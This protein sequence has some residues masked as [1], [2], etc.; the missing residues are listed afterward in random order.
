MSSSPS[1]RRLFLHQ[2]GFASLGAPP[3]IQ[4]FGALG[5]TP[6]PA[7]SAA[8]VAA[9][10]QALNRF[11]RMMQEWLVAQVRQAEAEGA[12]LRSALKTK[13]DAE[14]YV[15]NVRKKI[16]A[17][18]GPEPEKTPLNAR[19]IRTVER[20]TYRIENVIFESRP[21]FP[22]TANLYVPKGPGGK[23]PGVVGVCGHSLNGKA[24]EAYQSF[25]QGLARMG[26][27][28]LIFDPAGQ[29]ER[30]EYLDGLK[31]RYKGGVGEHIQA[32]NQLSLIGE[33]LA[34]WFAWDGIRALDYLLTRPEVAPNHVGIT[35]NSGGGTQTTWLC[36]VEPRFTMA[37]PACFVTTFR[38]NAENELPA[39]TEQCPPGVL[40]QHLDHA[41]F[42]VAMAPKPVVILAQEK[43]FFDARG[44]EEAYGRLKGLYTLLGKPDNIQLHVGS[45]YHG[46]TQGN[47]EAMYR[48]FNSVT[49]VSNADK[50][51]ALVIEKDETLWCT[52][53]GQVSELHAR[54]IFSF[55]KERSQSL[56]K[57][58]G[59]LKEEALRTAVMDLLKMP[60]AQGVPDFRILR[61]IGGR[62]YPLKN[63]AAYAV[64][65]EPGIHALVTR[66]QEDPLISRPP[67]GPARAVLYVS[68]LSADAELREEPLVA[69]LLKEEPSA[70]FFGCDLRGIGDSRPDICGTDQFLKPYGSD[71]FLSA[72]GVMLDRPYLGQKVFDVLRVLEW[73]AA[74]GHEEVHLAGK[75]W[76][77]LAAAFAALFS[78][79]V[80]QVTLKGALRSFAEVAET[81]D[82]R[83]PYSALLPGVLKQF[84]LPDCYRALEAKK[85]RLLD[86]WGAEDGLKTV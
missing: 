83:W 24:A 14:A 74:Q 36:G 13:E 68:H 38:R 45:D 55:T 52:P 23:M 69:E 30:F 82:Y 46:Y 2:A 63:H 49:G 71:Y 26:Y 5:A 62:K 80:R 16:R 6:A 73:V 17:C 53:H 43:D 51:P 21:G 40:A 58:R 86:P 77:A 48:F 22:V 34:A 78:P 3:L 27:V 70:A 76:G 54:T 44:S 7:Q 56:S 42:L 59:A 8:K 32:G 84:D 1:S 29:G 41:D 79:R 61:T 37:A 85:L 10:I 25:A 15:R 57:Q 66:L 18:F 12:R 65:T 35:G 28:V 75:G 9:D 67:K 19:T 33:S 81:E 31:S 64:E 47:R 11:P 4:M 20:D 50:E 39:D 72:H 60:A